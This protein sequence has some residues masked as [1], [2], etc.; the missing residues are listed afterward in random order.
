MFVYWKADY[1]NSFFFPT[2]SL[3]WIKYKC[4]TWDKKVKYKAYVLYKDYY[5]FICYSKCMVEYGTPYCK[6]N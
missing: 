6:L 2:S 4:A 5:S 3:A 1:Q